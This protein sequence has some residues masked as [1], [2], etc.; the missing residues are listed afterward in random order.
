M[1]APAAP[2]AKATLESVSFS[3]YS[4][5]DMGVNPCFLQSLSNNTRRKESYSAKLTLC[6]TP[7]VRSGPV[8]P[9]YRALMD[10][11]LVREEEDD[12]EDVTAGDVI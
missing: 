3:R 5:F 9:A 10:R 12:E 4:L 7:M 8:S 2:D 11:L 1:T 6:I